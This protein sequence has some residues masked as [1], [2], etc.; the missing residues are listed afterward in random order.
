MH[1]LVLYT[2]PM[3]AESCA[4]EEEEGG[5]SGGGRDA[6]HFRTRKSPEAKAAAKVS[7]RLAAA[8]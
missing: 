5:E 6:T 1:K 2:G 3:Q 4:L 8:I 7:G